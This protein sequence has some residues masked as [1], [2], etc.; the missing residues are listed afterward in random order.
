M[1]IK[2]T[3]A[4]ARKAAL[5]ATIVSLLL[6]VAFILFPRFFKDRLDYDI[7]KL[8]YQFLLLTVIG[9]TIT[10]LFT[11]YMKLREEQA[12]R[13]EQKKARRKEKR[14][15]Q[16]KFY[17]EFSQAH[18]DGKK[19][20]RFLRARTRQL[21]FDAQNKEMILLRTD[22]YDELLKELTILQLKFESLLDEV[23]SNPEL[24]ATGDV[25]SL[26]ENMEKIEE[27]L[28]Q[29]VSEY[30]NCYRFHPNQ[31]FIDDVSYLPLANFDKLKEFIGPY[32]EATCFK[33]QFKVAA[34]NV[35]KILLGILASSNPDK[36]RA[37][38]GV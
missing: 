25:N 34:R 15:L 6:V 35:S 17:T 22:R 33:Y 16:R 3:A 11:F 27:Y 28:N 1:D 9:G 30:E 24:F 21:S 36:P 10:F 7:F 4:K 29:M 18:N 31:S 23:K 37:H 32:K 14:S 2:K 5:A 26:T 13:E 38:P 8:T 12:R 19:I 20:R